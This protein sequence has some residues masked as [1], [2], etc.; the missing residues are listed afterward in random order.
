MSSELI[1]SRAAILLSSVLLSFLIVDRLDYPN[2]TIT[3]C[4][5]KE[6]YF[7]CAMPMKVTGSNKKFNKIFSPHEHD[8]ILVRINNSTRLFF[9][10]LTCDIYYCKLCGKV[11]NSRA[12]SILHQK[13]IYRSNV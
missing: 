6:N 13:C 3:E 11:L 1:C 8:F 2:S 12:D 5:D 7:N 9:K 10:C 4:S